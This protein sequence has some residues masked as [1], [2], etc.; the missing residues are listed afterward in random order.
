VPGTEAQSEP[1]FLIA[2]L[3]VLALFIVLGVLAVKRFTRRPE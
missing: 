2:Q 3:A 1:P